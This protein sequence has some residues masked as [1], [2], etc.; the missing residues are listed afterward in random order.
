MCHCNFTTYLFFSCCTFFP[1]LEPTD[2]FNQTTL[3]HLHCQIFLFL[4]IICLFFLSLHS[5]YSITSMPSLGLL[6]Q[7]PFLCLP[8]TLGFQTREVISGLINHSLPRACLGIHIHV[9]LLPWLQLPS[10]KNLSTPGALFLM[11][12]G[13][14]LPCYY[15]IGMS[16]NATILT[17][18]CYSHQSYFSCIC[19]P[20]VSQVS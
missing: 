16:N 8:L 12:H 1:T 9:Y 4:K 17:T 2:T 6:H 7:N 19:H 13:I 11:E 15:F 20:F 3:W 10:G 18:L 5:S 14:F